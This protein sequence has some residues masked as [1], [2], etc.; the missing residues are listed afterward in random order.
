VWINYDYKFQQIKNILRP[1]FV[2]CRRKMKVEEDLIHFSDYGILAVYTKPQTKYKKL[3][4]LL[5]EVA[6][7]YKTLR[8]IAKRDRVNV[9]YAVVTDFKSWEF[10][11]YDMQLE[12]N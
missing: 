11:R 2:L 8:E 5:S 1:D 7:I 6:K 10:M 4:G 9:V 3:K 12:V